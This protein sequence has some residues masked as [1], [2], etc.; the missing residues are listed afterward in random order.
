M[1]LAILIL[2]LFTQ[3][4]CTRDVSDKEPFRSF[5]GKDVVLLRPV[6]TDNHPDNSG[7]LSYSLSE[8]LYGNSGRLDPG[9][10]LHVTCV[11][12]NTFL[13]PMVEV[14]GTGVDPANGD[15]FD[16]IYNWGYPWELHRAPW[17]D[18]NTVPEVRPIS[19]RK[20]GG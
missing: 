6:S 16:W 12:E 11:E 9:T 20:S 13:T 10:T 17:E 14:H 18:P 3:L 2:I 4:G 19:L 8:T 15:R 1:R 5:V 7:K